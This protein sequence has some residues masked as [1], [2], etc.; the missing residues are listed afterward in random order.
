MQSLLAGVRMQGWTDSH[1]RW[2][3]TRTV[4]W[5]GPPAWNSTA[6]LSFQDA[7]GAGGYL[8]NWW[9][10]AGTRPIR[11]TICCRSLVRI[12]LTKPSEAGPQSHSGHPCTMQ[13]RRA[14]KRERR[15]V[16]R[17]V[18]VCVCEYVCV[19]VVVV[20]LAGWVDGWACEGQVK[21]AFRQ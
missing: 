20:V 14:E 19:C 7:V 15:S 11:L 21:G 3:G 13:P 6:R 2:T 1:W 8:S 12:S 16:R 4:L 18:C 17:C 10:T 5:A 9:S